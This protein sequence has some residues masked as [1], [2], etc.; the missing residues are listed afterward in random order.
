[1]VWEERSR[2]A[3]L[4]IQNQEILVDGRSFH[5]SLEAQ[6]IEEPNEEKNAGQRN[7]DRAD[8]T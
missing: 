6:G 5:V 8:D 1:V 2:E 7:Q 4:P 3:D